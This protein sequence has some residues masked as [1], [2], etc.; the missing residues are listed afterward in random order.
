MLPGGTVTSPE[1]TYGI[2]AVFHTV[3]Q[4]TKPASSRTPF[5]PLFVTVTPLIAGFEFKSMLMAATLLFWNALDV[6]VELLV[7]NLTPDV[8][9]LRTTLLVRVIGTDATKAAVL[10]PPAWLFPP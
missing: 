1:R 5:S 4:Y 3:L 2:D 6:N 9:E 8:I 10:L 7:C